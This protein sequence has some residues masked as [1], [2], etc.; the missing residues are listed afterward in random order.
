MSAAVCSSR[1]VFGTLRA[2]MS[3]QGRQASAMLPNW[4]EVPWPVL[5]PIRG[6]LTDTYFAND[7]LV[8]VFHMMGASGARTAVIHAL[9]QTIHVESSLVEPDP[10]PDPDP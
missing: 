9:V 3:Q 8:I 5:R 4:H 6:W 7:G 2:N 10:E 1:R